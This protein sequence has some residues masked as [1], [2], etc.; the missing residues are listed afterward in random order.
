[1]SAV[2]YWALDINHG[3]LG[4]F[5]RKSWF[6]RVSTTTV[7]RC[8]VPLRQIGSSKM[9]W[10]S[11]PRCMWAIRLLCRLLL[12]RGPDWQPRRVSSWPTGVAVIVCVCLLCRGRMHRRRCNY[13]GAWV[14]GTVSRV[15]YNGGE[16]LKGFPG[17][18][19]HF[20]L[21]VQ[22]CF[23]VVV[24]RTILKLLRGTPCRYWATGALRAANYVSFS[25][26]VQ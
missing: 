6:H 5:F 19:G 14:V 10:A 21:R 18:L 25:R 23:R 8:F 7:G 15:V 20:Q 22:C 26:G 9:S 4:Q 11:F 3:F 2:S 12:A 16:F 17:Q 1:V 24:S 13:L